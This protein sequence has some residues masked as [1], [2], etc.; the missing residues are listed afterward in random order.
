MA[1]PPCYR[2]GNEQLPSWCGDYSKPFQ[3]SLWT[4]QLLW[5]VRGFFLVAHLLETSTR[6]TFQRFLRKIWLAEYL[7]VPPCKM[8][9]WIKVTT[10][11]HSFQLPTHLS[12][13]STCLLGEKY[14]VN[15][16]GNFPTN[17]YKRSWGFTTYSTV[18]PLLKFNRDQSC[19]LLLMDQKSQTT[20]WDVCIRP[21][22]RDFFHQQ[23]DGGRLDTMR[24]L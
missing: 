14:D 1:P 17:A 13:L 4:N 16:K 5:K 8:S 3:G 18:S 9:K 15:L 2:V 11:F 7:V 6:P 22:V 24:L 12:F 10:N 19:I 21:L 20:T 23:H